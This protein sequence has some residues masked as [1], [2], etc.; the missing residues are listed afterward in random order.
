MVSVA[1]HNSWLRDYRMGEGGAIV[2]NQQRL[3]GQL[4]K[5]EKKIKQLAGIKLLCVDIKVEEP[6][7]LRSV[8]GHHIILRLDLAGVNFSFSNCPHRINAQVYD[9]APHK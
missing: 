9:V 4:K 5:K 6:Q 3:F 7:C 8:D 2:E 1:G